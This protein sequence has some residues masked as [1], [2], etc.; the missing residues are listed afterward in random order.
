[1]YELVN[2][3]IPN[4]LLPGTHGY[5]TVAMTR[6][7]SD[8]LRVRLE[9]FCAYR[10]R[11]NA[12]D[13]TYVRENPVNWFH[14]VLP[15][16]VH[17]VGCVAPSDFDYTGRTN[18][19]ARILAFGKD[20]MPPEGGAAILNAVRRRLRE[21]WS[22]NA[23]WLEVDAGAAGSLL[24]DLPKREASASAWRRLFGDERGLDLARRFANLLLSNISAGGRPICFKT[25][26]ERD[27]DGTELLG[28]FSDLIELLPYDRRKAVAFG[29]YPDSFPNG[30]TCHLRGVYDRD[31][32]F[33]T[34]T[35]TS[36][37][38][39]CETKTVHNECSL[40]AAEVPRPAVTQ[41]RMSSPA[42]RR[43]GV[44]VTSPTPMVPRPRQNYLPPPE[45]GTGKFV[46]GVIAAVV[47]VAV[48]AVAAVVFWLRDD[49]APVVA[50]VFSN[51]T[52]ATRTDVQKEEVHLDAD[53]H[54][55]NDNQRVEAARAKAETEE[56]KAKAAEDEKVAAE[57][58]QREENERKLREKAQREEAERKA[59]EDAVAFVRATEI[60]VGRPE[61]P[62]LPK[63]SNVSDDLRNEYRVFYYLHGDTLLTNGVAR[64]KPIKFQGSIRD[65]KLTFEGEDVQP[66]DVSVQSKVKPLMESCCVVWLSGETARYEFHKT[67]R[68]C[69][70]KD[71]DSRNLRQ[72]CFGECEEIFDTWRK[73]SGNDERYSIVAYSGGKIIIDKW[74]CGE[75]TLSVSNVAE[76]LCGKEAKRVEQLKKE[77]AGL[78]EKYESSKKQ[79]NSA[80]TKSLKSKLD[81]AMNNLK[82]ASA[83]LDN[84]KQEAAKRVKEMEFEVAIQT[85][86]KRK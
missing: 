81:A 19:L 72:T 78:Q 36:P 53:K 13:D 80:E 76:R 70:F 21:P 43:Q 51:R 75:A 35:A 61:K 8:A 7:L 46:I 69:W 17:A 79:K 1:M 24:P 74:P 59:R 64:Y 20:E 3:S 37:W 6:G 39:D 5:S 29:T 41:T 54:A 4:G 22:G 32:T 84:A 9:A 86:E 10:H 60:L 30:T 82:N 71:A 11:T 58:R 38:I 34:A 52:A 33:E 16:G 28:L 27:A 40:P 77:K 55:P 47:L 68:S 44:D 2:T 25:S 83:K 45:T 56:K 85:K 49:E 26:A 12:H 23:R 15:Q 67:N 62:E 73:Q 48:A 65:Y 31:R 57:K 63:P 14:V 66:Q 50:D 42:F 18:R